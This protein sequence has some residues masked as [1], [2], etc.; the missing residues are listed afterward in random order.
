MNPTQQALTQIAQKKFQAIYFLYGDE[1]Y[2]IQEWINQ[3]V[4]SLKLNQYSV[5]KFDG[6]QCTLN[7]IFEAV[8]TTSLF[9]FNNADSGSEKIVIVKHANQLKDTEALL[10]KLQAAEHPWSDSLL[11]FWADTLDGRKKL[12]QFLKKNKLAFEFKKATDQELIQW[13]GYLAKKRNIK[14]TA[15]IAELLAL[16]CDSSLYLLEQA[17]E[18]LALAVAFREDPSVDL[19]LV[20]QTLALRSTFETSELIKAIFEQKKSRAWLL[21]DRLLQSSEDALGFV[22]YF[23]WMFKNQPSSFIQKNK[24]R[25]LDRLAVLDYRLKSTGL[26]PKACVENFILEVIGK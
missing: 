10:Q 1:P 24:S 15:E 17:V 2:K 6:S 20:S 11:I 25:V 19:N 23:T 8:Q 4:A 16:H 3:A 22:G 14:L 5:Q 12:H 21:V 26:E 18:K 7:D 9:A 13:A